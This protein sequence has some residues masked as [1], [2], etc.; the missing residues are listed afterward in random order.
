MDEPLVVVQ[1]Q[2][3]VISYH[4]IFQIVPI[5]GKYIEVKINNNRSIRSAGKA[6]M[7]ES[8]RMSTTTSICSMASSESVRE[9]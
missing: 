4:T 2:P 6:I 3:T 5:R 7:A 8:I 1:N 9:M